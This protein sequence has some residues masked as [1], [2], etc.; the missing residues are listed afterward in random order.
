M[1]ATVYGTPTHV[2]DLGWLVVALETKWDISSVS[3]Q[4]LLSTRITLEP[5]VL[6]AWKRSFLPRT[7]SGVET[8]MLE[9]AAPSF[10]P[11]PETFQGWSPRHSL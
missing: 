8:E 3:L 4:I 5:T 10:N 2:G 11:S 7:G 1:L 9:L 6:C